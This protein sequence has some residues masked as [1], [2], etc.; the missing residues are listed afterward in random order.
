MKGK[1]SHGESKGQGM[2]ALSWDPATS[3]APPG[4]QA[5]LLVQFFTDY[6]TYYFYAFTVKSVQARLW[7]HFVLYVTR[8]SQLGKFLQM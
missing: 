3:S 5:G 8:L 1:S 6:V 2:K 4:A 7:N